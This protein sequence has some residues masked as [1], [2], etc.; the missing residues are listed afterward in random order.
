M[1]EG[2]GRERRGRQRENGEAERERGGREKG[3]AEREGGGRERTGREREER[4][5]LYVDFAARQHDRRTDPVPFACLEP[6][7]TDAPYPCTER[8]H[9]RAHVCVCACARACTCH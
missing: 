4:I 9:V 2:G 3:E 7:P 8:A 6:N 1:G 5:P